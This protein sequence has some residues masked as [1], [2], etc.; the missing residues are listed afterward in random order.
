M[1]EY[2]VWFLIGTSSTV[3]FNATKKNPI[4]VYPRSAKQYVGGAWVNKTAKIYQGGVWADF[5][6]WIIRDGKLN[7]SVVTALNL[8]YSEGSSGYIR[9]KNGYIQVETPNGSYNRYTSDGYI[10][11]SQFTK[12]Y[13]DYESYNGADGNGE[14]FALNNKTCLLQNGDF[15][16]SVVCVDISAVDIDCTFSLIARAWVTGNDTTNK[17]YN[18]W[19]E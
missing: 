15:A 12:L 17:Y 11:T 18:L 2:D 14:Q 13:L 6:F 9:F 10:P 16:R 19:L 8:E 4:M 7:T 5:S 1:A 3:A